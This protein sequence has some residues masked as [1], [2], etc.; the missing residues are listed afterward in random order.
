MLR[1]EAD[2]LTR[3]IVCS[4]S[5]EYFLVENLKDHNIVEQA[6][7]EQAKKQHD[8]LKMT[9]RGFGAEVIDVGE[10]RSHPNSVFTRDSSICTPQG[11]VR[12]RLGLESRRGE[13]EWM[14]QNL[15]ELGEPFAGAIRPPGTV[16]GGDIILAGSVAFIGL[17]KRTNKEG[18]KQISAILQR[19][20]YETRAFPVP[21]PHFHLGGLMSLIGPKQTLCCKNV[22]PSDFFKGFERIELECPLSISSNVSCL[23]NSELIIESSN[24][25]AFKVLMKEGFKIHA[26]NLSEFVKGEGGPTC[27]ILPVERVAY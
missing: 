3:V 18:V 23:G 21:L 9:I 20:D 24:E 6:D 5:K 8:T 2:R 12:L 7:A 22:F 16:E 1:S 10:L 13:E 15:D 26:I 25:A 17:S 11:Y 14:S 19:M 4:P 27:L